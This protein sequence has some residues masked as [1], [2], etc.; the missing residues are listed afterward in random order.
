MPNPATTRFE[1]SPSGLFVACHHR[2]GRLTL[3]DHAANGVSVMLH[4]EPGDVAWLRAECVAF[5]DAQ[6]AQAEEGV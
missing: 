2:S 3:S 6:T 1:E 4:L 5:L